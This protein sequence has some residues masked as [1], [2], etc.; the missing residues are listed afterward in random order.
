M[1]DFAHLHVHSDFSTL[2]G[3]STMAQYCAR[4]QELGHKSISFTETGSLRGVSEVINTAKEHELKPIYGIQFYVC[5]D[6]SRRGLTPDEREHITKGLPQSRW[7]SALSEYEDDHGIN[8][9]HYLT[10]WAQTQNGLKNLFGLSSKSWVDGFYY[11]PRIDID[12]LIK[13]GDGLMVGTNN[14]QSAVHSHYLAGRRRKALEIAD[15]LREAFGERLWLEIMPHGIFHQSKANQFSLELHKR[16]GKKVRLLATQDAHYVAQGGHKYQQMLAAIGANGKELD[17]CGL[18]GGDYWFKSEAEMRAGFAKYHSAIPR[19]LV[20]RAIRN[21]LVLTE[22][23]S[24]VLSKDRFQCIMPD[25][26]VAPAAAGDEAL[27]LKTLCLQGWT[28]RQIPERAAKYAKKHGLTYVEALAIYKNRL[29]M[30]LGALKRQKFVRYILFVRELYGWVREQNIACG[31]GRGSAAGSI[32]NYLIGITAVDPVEHGLLFE[33]FISPERIDMPDIDMDFEDVRRPEII[34]HIRDKYGEDSVSQIA[35][36]GKLKGKACLRDVS[37]VLKIPPNEIG[38]VTK[39]ILER[40]SGDERASMTIVDSFKEFEVCRQFAT[41]YPAVLEYAQALEGLSKTLG[42]HAAGVVTSPVPLDQILPMETRDHEGVRVPV[43][44]VDFWGAEGF[45]LLKLDVLGLRTMT[46]L[47]IAREDVLRRHG[48]DVDYE[49]LPL[50]D[51]PTLEGFTN[52]DYTG[53]FQ[54]DS[55]GADKICSGVEFTDFEDIAA[56]T[57]LN[58][59]GT[60]RSGLAGQYVA[61]KKNPALVSKAAFHPAVSKITSDTLGIIVYQ[62]HVIKIFTEVAGFNPATAD[63]LRKKIAKKAGDETLGKERDRFIEGAMKNTGMTKKQ[64]SQIMDAITFFGSY[65]FNKSHATAYGMIAYWCMYM[66]IHYPLE[67]FRALLF[68]EPRHDRIQSVAKDAKAHGIPILP[69][70]VS[71][72]K[73][74]FAID[75]DKRAIRGSLVDIKGVG[76]AAS[77][78]IMANQPYVDFWDFMARV[79]ARKVHKGVVKSLALAGALD[80]LLPNVKWFIEHIEHIWKLKGQKTKQEELRNIVKISG[81]LP[82]YDEEEKALIASRVSPL[83]FGKHPIDAYSDFIDKHVGVKLDPMGADDFWETH[84]TKDVGGFFVC[85]VI[86]EVR[87]NQV[88]DFHQGVEPDEAEKARMGWGRQY[89]NINLEGSDGKQ[90]RIKFD[91]DIFDEYRHI[92]IDRGKGT[93]CIVHVSGNAQF[94]SLRAHF[95]IDVEEY[96]KKTISGESLSYW[97]AIVSGRHPSLDYPFKTKRKRE[98]ACYS[99]EKIRREAGAVA[100]K[101]QRGDIVHFTVIGVVTHVREKL[102]KR[103]AL[104]GFFGILGID[105]YIDSLCFGSIWPQVRKHLKSQ[106]LVQI[107]L[108]YNRGQGI[109]SGGQLRVLKSAK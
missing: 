17:E 42:M 53:I 13:Y 22:C 59:P 103:N 34:Q 11:K 20:S 70:D 89:A 66:K 45:G 54:Y 78:S 47:R 23:A 5:G 97:E 50:D 44:A 18:P 24:A 8:D 25:V 75:D 74:G 61:R 96:R 109:Y 49:L 19:S 7:K 35:T 33:R 60:A 92:V 101:R 56:M 51:K 106:S 43:T 99:L 37:R 36:V 27:Y 77:E 73:R 104:M 14:Y 1:E 9:R 100:R 93:P 63:S 31:P 84:D 88:G 15:K 40:S 57:A 30:E 16:Y 80:G 82:D 95:V 102:D 62:E 3:A 58:R 28:W 68:C 38:P 48:I 76:T 10:V 83:A 46:V 94:E 98:H 26:Y 107:E 6:M 85:G 65:G 91:W 79:D 4:A 87:L 21:T 29:R 71:V 69:P 64:A 90:R 39:A 67:F 86:I 41:K 72:S 108:E 52:H 2:E 55:P 81:H 105:G 32:V 12:T